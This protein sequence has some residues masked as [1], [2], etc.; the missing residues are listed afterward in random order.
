MAGTSSSTSFSYSGYHALSVSGGAVQWPPLG[1]GLRLHPTKPSS[2]T[3]RESSPIELAIGTPGD[4]GSWHTPT[5][6]SGYRSTTRL[7]RSLH[8]IAHRRLTDSSPT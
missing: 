5:N 8:A 3:H 4:W 1:S 7:M 2:S 6:V